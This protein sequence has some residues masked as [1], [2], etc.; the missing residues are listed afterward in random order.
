MI[1]NCS[2]SLTKG[3]YFG[4]RSWIAIE[5][6]AVKSQANDF[7]LE[8]HNSAHWDLARVESALCS[9]KR[10]LHPEFVGV[11][12]LAAGHESIVAASMQAE[13]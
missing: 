7:F 2:A 10:F 13:D 3:D 1:A 4:M 5:D 11:I 9:P 8:N 12:A 6:I